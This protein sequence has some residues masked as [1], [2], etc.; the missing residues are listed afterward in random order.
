MAGT[1]EHHPQA[2]VP[3][4]V[5]DGAVEDYSRDRVYVLTAVVLTA[6]TAV[7][8]ATYYLSDFPLFKAPFLVPTLLLLGAVKF[9]IVAYI[10]MHLKFDKKV[11]TTIFYSG[12]VLALLVYLAVLTVFR[13]WTPAD[14]AIRR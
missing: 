7:E 4:Q 11:L 8:V 1:H 10:F 9:F 5:L 6:I 13:F 14:Y 3:T 2:K 12:V